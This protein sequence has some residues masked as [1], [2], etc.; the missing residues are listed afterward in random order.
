PRLAQD[1]RAAVGGWGTRLQE[2]FESATSVEDLREKL[3]AAAPELGMD[4]YAAVMGLA[5][6][7]AHLAG[8]ND[9]QDELAARGNS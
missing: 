4:E 6:E 8:R 1:L 5:L 9:V 2:I 7:A 3:L